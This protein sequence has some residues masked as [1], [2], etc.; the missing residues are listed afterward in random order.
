MNRTLPVILAALGLASFAFAGLEPGDTVK[1]SLRGLEATEQQKV[2]GEYKVGEAGGVSLPLLDKPVPA[3]G[4]SAEQFARAAEAAYRSE[5]IYTT[6]KIEAEAVKGT[7]VDNGPSMVSI[8][9]H[10]KRAGDVQYRQGLTVVRAINGAGGRD[11]FASR[12]VLLIRN[13]KS[14]WIDYTKLEHKNIVLLPNDALQVDQHGAITDRW[15]GSDESVKPL[16]K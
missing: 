12:N 14:Y 6:P 4:L 13:G 11:D 8:G 1:V 2:N 7:T 15:K 16:L 5:G 9:G 3:R 10:V